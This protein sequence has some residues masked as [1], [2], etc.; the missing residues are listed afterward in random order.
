MSAE[1]IV[2]V[3]AGLSG[4][5]LAEGL[6]QRGF[7]GEIVIIGDED[8]LPY[9][10]PPLSKHVLSGKWSLEQTALVDEVAPAFSRVTWRLGRRAVGLV[11]SE[12]T[13]LLDDGSRETGTSVVVATGV[14]ARRLRTSAGER[15]ATL[16][17][18]DDVER[19]HRMLEYSSPEYPVVV[20]GGGFLGAEVA[21]SMHARGREVIVLESASAPLVGVLG[22]T[23][24]GWLKGLAGAVGIDLRVDQNVIDVAEGREG[25]L[26][27][28]CA[29]GEA[30]RAGLVV[31]AVGSE[32]DLDWLDGSGL[33]LDDGVLVDQD[34]RASDGV[35]AIG[36]VA[37]FIWASP[38]GLQRIRLEHWQVAVDHAA[39]LAAHVTGAEPPAPMTPYFWSDQYG[40]KIQVLGSPQRDDTIHL[41]HGSLDESKWLALYERAGRVSA[42]LALNQPRALMV[43]KALVDRGAPVDE[44]LEIAPW[45]S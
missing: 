27:V 7:E 23:A 24:A 30:I 22:D 32:L 33:E 36:D 31:A 34:L 8:R 28:E 40:R 3:G 2:I 35:F 39:Q 41:V 14:R 11:A 17:R 44:A 37:R 26:L 42:L 29:Q 16:R 13:V 4:W 19:L 18:A 43:S 12:R 45:A 21:T 6:V 38:L 5:R 25:E 1:R 15:V 20:I 9:D 10:R